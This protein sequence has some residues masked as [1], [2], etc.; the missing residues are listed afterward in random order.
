MVE[1]MYDQS[2]EFFKKF[3]KNLKFFFLNNEPG[4]SQLPPNTNFAFATH[5]IQ[6][7]SCTQSLDNDHPHIHVLIKLTKDC[8]NV[9]NKMTTFVVPCLFSSFKHLIFGWSKTQLSGLKFK[10]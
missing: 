7:E 2:P 5:S 6:N 3:Q 10:K 4:I 9:V 1:A 8:V